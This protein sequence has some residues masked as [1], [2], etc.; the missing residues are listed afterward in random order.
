[1][2]SL[3]KKYTTTATTKTH[4]EED[5]GLV[6]II[7]PAVPVDT[8]GSAVRYGIGFLGGWLGRGYKETRTFG[9]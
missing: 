6:D 9:F 7:N 2:A 1:M 8:I 3:V 4:G 5:A